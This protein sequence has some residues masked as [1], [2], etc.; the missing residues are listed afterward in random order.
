LRG[1][2]NSI[3]ESTTKNRK[4]KKMIEFT[5]IDDVIAHLGLQGPDSNSQYI[6]YGLKVQD[7]TIQSHIDHANKYIY[8]IAPN[9]D[10]SDT[11]YISAQL[12][13]LDIACIGILVTSVGGSLVGA[14]DY[15]LGDMRVAKSGPYAF[16]IKQAIDGYSADAK[17]NISNATTP[18][19]SAKAVLGSKVPNQFRA[20]AWPL[21]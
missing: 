2:S 11:R 9:L 14:F 17:R 15:F 10:P 3:G 8:S 6:V 13:A 21:S 18:L 1:L 19:M 12:A 20:S 7:T 16:A 4:E 5:T